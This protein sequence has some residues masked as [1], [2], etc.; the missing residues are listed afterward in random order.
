MAQSTFGVVTIARTSRRESD[1]ELQ[2]QHE[3]FVGSR[4]AAKQIEQTR[5]LAAGEPVQWQGDYLRGRHTDGEAG[6]PD[7]QT[8]V[9]FVPLC[10]KHLR[11]TERSPETYAPN[12]ASE[13]A[14]LTHL[15][16]NTSRGSRRTE[17]TAQRSAWRAAV[18]ACPHA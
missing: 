10:S 7:H 8:R 4:G 14:R 9:T 16:F 6:A 12:R 15:C 2:R 18:T 17:A 13:I 1:E 3:F 5:R 11:R